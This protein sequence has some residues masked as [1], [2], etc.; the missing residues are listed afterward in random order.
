MTDNMN[1]TVCG[2]SKGYPERINQSKEI[3][4]AEEMI[5]ISQLLDDKGNP[6]P[7]SLKDNLTNGNICAV[8]VEMEDGNQLFLQPKSQTM[9]GLRE[10]LVPATAHFVRD[11]ETQESIWRLPTVSA[12]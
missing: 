2:M 10:E 4:Q 8:V 12:G 3:P 9:E 6:I 7:Q 5:P 1:T 11:E